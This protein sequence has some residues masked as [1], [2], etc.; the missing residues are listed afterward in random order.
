MKPHFFISVIALVLTLVAPAAMAQQVC[1]DAGEMKAS[2]IDW[3]GER[4]VSAPTESNEQ[5][6][7]S[8]DTGTWTMIKLLSDG[9]ACVLAQGNEWMAGIDQGEL[10][11]LLEQ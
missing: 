9:K 7:A 6:W 8:K 1:M 4:P 3:Y 2:L 5:L 10:L 11:A